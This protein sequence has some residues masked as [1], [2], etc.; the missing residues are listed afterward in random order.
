VTLWLT[1]PA[2]ELL[3]RMAADPRN[4]ST[5]PALTEHGAR[6]EMAH[7]L[8]RRAPLYAALANHVLDTTGRGVEAVVEAALQRLHAPGLNAEIQDDRPGR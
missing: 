2:D 6:R 7:L 8:A 5:R 3:R 4:A 1:A